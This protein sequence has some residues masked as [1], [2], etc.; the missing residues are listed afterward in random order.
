MVDIQV[1][2]SQRRFSIAK[3]AAMAVPLSSSPSLPSP[4]GAVIIFRTTAP[5]WIVFASPMNGFPSREAFAVAKNMFVHLVP[6]RRP[7]HWRPALTARFGNRFKFPW[8]LMANKSY[9]HAGSR[10]ILHRPSSQPVCRRPVETTATLIA[11]NRVS[12]DSFCRRNWN[13]SAFLDRQAV[14]SR[15]LSRH[16]FV[17]S[18]HQNTPFRCLSLL[19]GAGQSRVQVRRALW[20]TGVLRERFGDVRLGLSVV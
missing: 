2:V 13:N 4:V 9:A 18:T 20:L 10:T 3:L 12:S 19:F 17:L 5:C 16:R 14:G 15:V 7:G 11:R 1:S 6:P 8:R